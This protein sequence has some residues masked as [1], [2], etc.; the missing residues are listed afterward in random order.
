[1][2]NYEEELNGAQLDAVRYLDGPSLVI[3]GAGSGKTR[4]LTY[5]IA[6]LLEHGYEPWSILALTFTN[7]AAGEMKERIAAR[8]GERA[9]SML[10]MGTFHSVF[11]KILRRESHHIGYDPQFTIYDQSDSRSLVKSIIKEM[12]LDDKVYKPNAVAERISAAKSSLVSPSD[13]E[14][15]GGLRGDDVRARIP[16]VYEIYKRYAERC[17]LANAMDF[18][19]LLV[20]T[21]RLF[22]EHPDVCRQY[23]ERFRYVLVDEYQDTNYVQ[24]CIVWQ[25]TQ[26]RRSIC[27][28]GDDAQSIYS[29]RGA[30][31]GNILGFTERYAGAR[32]FKLEQ[33]Y[34]STKMI[35]NA[36]NSL[37]SRNQE[38]IRKTVFSDRGEGE[39][40]A[41][42]SAYSDFEEGEIVANKI[43]ALRRSE[44]LGYSDFAILY[45]TNAQSRIFEEAFRKRSF[46]Y[47]IFGGLSFYQRKEIKDVIAYF[48]L[49]CNRKDEEA[50][51]R[52]INYPARGIGDKSVLKVK[53]RA[54]ANNTSLWDVL[55]DPVGC[56]LD[57]NKG[58]LSKLQNFASMI[59]NFS[60]LSNE[61]NAIEVARAVMKDSGIRD[62]IYNDNSVEGKARQE[63]IEELMNGIQD[64]VDVRREEGNT[65]DKLVDFLSEVSLMSDLDNDDDGDGERITLM[66]IHSAKGLEFR[67]VFIVG[68]EEE[69]FPNQ[70][71]Q[72]S[73]RE[74]EEERRLFYVAITRAKDHC[75]LSFAKSRYKYGQFNFCEPSRFI[76]EIDKRYIAMQGGV[77]KGTQSSL[78]GG[79]L[80]GRTN[81]AASQWRETSGSLRSSREHDASRSDTATSRM[82]NEGKMHITDNKRVINASAFMQNIEKAL[83][84]SDYQSVKHYFTDEGYGM[85]DTLSRYGR[86]TVVGS[87]EYTFLK[88]GNQVICRDINMQFDFRNHASFNRNVVFRFNDDS[89]KVESIAFRLSAITEQDIVGKSKWS[90]ESRMVLINFLEDYQTAYALKRYD[91]LESIFSDDALI[92][93]GHVVEKPETDMTDRK[94][95]NLPTKEVELLKMNKNQYFEIDLYPFWD[96]KAIVEIELNDEN[97]D[98]ELPK[99]LKLI[100]EVTDDPNYKNSSLANIK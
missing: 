3:A 98:I 76:N 77:Q 87:Q 53:E 22:K 72:S 12:Q 89:K 25:L 69:L 94:E 71:A 2:I 75:V 66:T 84:D 46:P 78:R 58:T 79:S 37:I 83:R 9:A 54:M 99:Q 10:W 48:R 88:F 67:T 13:Y 5:K 50:F 65:N 14:N 29:F 63:N 85:I 60:L 91:Y 95:L 55:L 56:G 1:M 4:V 93:V 41:L 39:P 27:V 40:L 44:G 31:I 11:S 20:N 81:S 86:I 28:V 51:K 19:D 38:Q 33:N 49:I 16:S 92:I 43:A 90:K 70:C 82:Y 96:D 6:Y 18:D 32:I 42:Y 97:Q 17:R 23:V 30:N 34:R 7:K 100:R 24:G 8:V 15:D 47:R 57:V 80:F 62:D 68:L 26:E 36:A 61:K 21:Y 52:I 64:F 45:R 35:V 59:E 74:L 73:L